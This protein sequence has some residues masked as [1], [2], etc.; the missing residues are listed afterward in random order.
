ME[1]IPH[2]KT[3]SKDL[4]W[5]QQNKGASKSRDLVGVPRQVHNLPFTIC[6]WDLGHLHS[7]EKFSQKIFKILKGPLKFF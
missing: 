7:E 5:Q 1:I 2:L 4:L 6:R 3:N